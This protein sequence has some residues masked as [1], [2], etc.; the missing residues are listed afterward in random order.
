MIGDAALASAVVDVFVLL[1][2]LVVC[3]VAGDFLRSL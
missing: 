1:G 3:L 2:G